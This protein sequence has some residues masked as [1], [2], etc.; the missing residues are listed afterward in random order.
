MIQ[1]NMPREFGFPLGPPILKTMTSFWVPRLPL[2]SEN[3]RTPRS[4]FFSC[5]AKFLSEL[6]FYS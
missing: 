5:K 2:F 3:S 6:E 1:F 4:P